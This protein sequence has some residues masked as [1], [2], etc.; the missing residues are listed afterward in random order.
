MKANADVYILTSYVSVNTLKTILQEELKTIY[1]NFSPNLE[2]E[3]YFRK[4]AKNRKLDEYERHCI[5]LSKRTLHSKAIKPNQSQ[6]QS[7]KTWVNSQIKI[8]S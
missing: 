7:L 2:V 4:L 1:F 5:K 3:T 8:K 6:L